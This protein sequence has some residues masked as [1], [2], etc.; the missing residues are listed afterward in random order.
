MWWKMGW[1]ATSISRWK[2][3]C[4]S[5]GNRHLGQQPLDMTRVG[6]GSPAEVRIK[7]FSLCLQS[8]HNLS[9]A[10]D[11]CMLA[12]HSAHILLCCLFLII[13]WLAPTASSDGSATSPY[14]HASIHLCSTPCLTRQAVLFCSPPLYCCSV[15]SRLSSGW[16]ILG[17][18]PSHPLMLFLSSDLHGPE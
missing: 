10:L 9:G 2:R 6:V 17:P 18:P 3:C 7:L 8:L 12:S 15:W 4:G 1:R 14:L 11:A 16:R 5:F 13:F